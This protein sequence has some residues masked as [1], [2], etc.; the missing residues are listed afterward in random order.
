MAIDYPAWY[1]LKTNITAILKVIATEEETET[2]GR[3]FTVNKDRWRPWIESQQ[4]IPL[5]NIMVQ[6][7]GQDSGRSSARACTTDD[8]VVNVDMYVV[9][10]AGEIQPVDQQAAE[11]LDLLVAQVREGLSRL[12]LIDYG[13]EMGKI[14]RSQN[15][16]LTYYDQENEQSTGQYAPA[17]W[18][19]NV[20]FPFEPQDKTEYLDLTELNVSMP[21]DLETIYKLKFNYP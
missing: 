15:L 9:G 11:R 12:D 3:D 1:Q 19:F 7:V 6:G 18:S 20:Q 14:D 10:K 13:F 2:P 8:V 17:R 21:D 16:T 4:S 5:V